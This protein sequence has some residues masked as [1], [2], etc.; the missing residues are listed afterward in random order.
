MKK[1]ILAG[2]LAFCA[3]GF[4]MAQTSEAVAVDADKAVPVVKV[5]D[6]GHGKAKG[7]A[8]CSSGENKEKAACNGESAK[9]SETAAA[10]C[11]SGGGKGPNKKG[12]ASASIGTSAA[13]PE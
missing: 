2:I 8:C 9:G 5:E 3:G 6:A 7:K 4:A 12:C 13:K 11:C 1:L 10:S